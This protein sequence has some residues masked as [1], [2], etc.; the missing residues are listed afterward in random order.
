MEPT[1]SGQYPRDTLN[2]HMQIQK[3]PRR[4][5][6]ESK[7][8]G[9]KA[10]RAQ[11]LSLACRRGRLHMVGRHP[12]LERELITW[13]PGCKWSPNGLDA[14]VHGASVLTNRWRNL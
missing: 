12:D 13:Y 8:R 9:S 11:P 3:V 2:A 6:V 10:D 5:I 7:A 1:G 4:P 14:L